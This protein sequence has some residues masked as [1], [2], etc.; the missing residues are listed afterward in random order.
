MKRQLKTLCISEKLQLIEQIESGRKKSIVAEEFKIPRS[1][2]STL[3]R[4]RD[5]IKRKF[6]E[7]DYGMKRKR[8]RLCVYSDIN[9]ALLAWFKMVHEQNI[10]INGPILKEKALHFAYLLGHKNF[11][12]SEGWLA[13]FKQRHE[14]V[15]KV[16][17]DGSSRK[18]YLK[19]IK[20]ED[21]PCEAP[22]DLLQELP[23][24]KQ[25]QLSESYSISELT[26]EGLLQ[27]TKNIF[28]ESIHRTERKNKRKKL[29]DTLNIAVDA[30][31]QLA[32]HSATNSEF[33][34]FGQHV[35]TQLQCLPLQESIQ[36][37]CDIQQ[38]ITAAR[39]RSIFK[40]NQ[41]SST[42]S[43]PQIS[44]SASEVRTYQKSLYPDIILDLENKD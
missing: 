20:T 33:T 30:F 34:I 32:N 16:I 26:A 44:S 22:E 9:D 35:A 21:H 6:S 42:D 31:K 5:E 37:Q 19:S 39:L 38:L 40:S 11:V 41:H 24:C 13:K 27:N 7:G 43:H 4:N 12:A 17:S 1:T 29:D 18:P 23:Q 25:T 36:L 15:A 2:V 3:W 28:P 10:P 14:V 8:A